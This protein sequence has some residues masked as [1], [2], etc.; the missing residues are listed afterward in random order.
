MPGYVFAVFAGRLKLAHASAVSKR[1]RKR[2]LSELSHL[3]CI[4]R[5]FLRALIGYWSLVSLLFIAGTRSLVVIR[6]ERLST[7]ASTRT[8]HYLSI[9]IWQQCCCWH[10][11]SCK[12]LPQTPRLTPPAPYFAFTS[13]TAAHLDVLRSFQNM[14]RQ[15]QHALL[16]G[17]YSRPQLATLGRPTRFHTGIY[18]TSKLIN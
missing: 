7:S 5:A 18:R 15:Q 3:S 10:R 17:R 12:E 6:P 1:R 16:P 2:F 4:Y 8:L 13:T 9:Q 14:L 11:C